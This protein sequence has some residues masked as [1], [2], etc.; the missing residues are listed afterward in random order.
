M[1]RTGRVK[2]QKVMSSIAERDEPRNSVRP[3]I[4]PF[5]ASQGDSPAVDD[6]R[7]MM[8]ITPETYSGVAVEAMEMVERVRS[9]RLP[10]FMPA[11]MPM[12]RA[13]GTMTEKAMS[14]SQPVS[15]RRPP[16]MAE[17]LLS[18]TV[19]NPRSP[20]STPQKVGAVSIVMPR[21]TQRPV[22]VPSAATRVQPGATPSHS[23]Y[24]TTRGRV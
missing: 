20:C 3:S 6:A 24:R 2:F 11:R 17:T 23:P 14:I 13:A 1:V 16:T 12:I 5:S 22:S 15:A 10:S 8:K 9:V 19:E 18:E 4:Q 7:R 21:S